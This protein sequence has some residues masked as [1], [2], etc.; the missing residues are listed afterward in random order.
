MARH[1]GGAFSGKD[2]TKVDRSA[3]YAARYVAKNLVAAGLADRC[4][5]QVAY[6]I[7]VA[8]PVSVLVE[9]FGTGKLEEAKLAELVGEF[10]DLRPAAIIHHLD[11]RRPIYQQTAAYGHFGR[12]DLDLPWEKTNKADELR[13][14]AG[15]GAGKLE[16]VR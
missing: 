12:T 16:L 1:G 3:A 7:G 8:R 4:E 9:T 11:L 14:A 10:F 5:V 2:P 15:L 13:S 6:A